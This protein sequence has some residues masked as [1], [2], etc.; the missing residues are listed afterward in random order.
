VTNFLIRPAT[1]ND[2]EAIV[3]VFNPIIAEGRYTAF[4]TPFTIE[5]ERAYIEQIS[6]RD[7][8]HVATK[9][10]DGR[11][12][13]FQTVS[14]FAQF[15]NAFDHV[16][17]LGTFVEMAHQRQ[18]IARQL[19]AATFAAARALGYE[20]LFTYVR[21]DNEGGLATYLSQGFRVVGV[22]QRQAKV[23][24]VYIDETIIERFLD[25]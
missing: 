18:G 1:P 3:A 6:P 14:P 4:D 13:G 8:F 15:T 10:E 7:I 2:A 17:T 16:G 11:I 19:F 20:K 22:A 24:G 25:A 12:V 21:A 23:N 9:R 5:E